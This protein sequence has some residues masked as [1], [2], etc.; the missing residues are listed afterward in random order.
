MLTHRQVKVYTFV[1]LTVIPSIFV[2]NVVKKHIYKSYKFHRTTVT[3]SQYHE[4]HNLL[5]QP[6]YL[7]NSAKAV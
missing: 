1:I 6:S 2:Q 5:G 4:V 7:I 3:Q